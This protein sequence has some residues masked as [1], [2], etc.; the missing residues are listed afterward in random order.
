MGFKQDLQ[1][2]IRRLLLKNMSEGQQFMFV[3]GLRAF[4]PMA[5][6]ALALS[7]CNYVNPNTPPASKTPAEIIEE[8]NA[9]WGSVNE[10]GQTGWC[11]GSPIPAEELE[12]MKDCINATPARTVEGATCPN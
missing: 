3:S 12:I 11:S 9:Y 7:S 2:T 5:Y 4:M 6:L 1:Y 10:L 8:H